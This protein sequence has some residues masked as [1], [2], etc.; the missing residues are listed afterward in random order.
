[1][2]TFGQA[3]PAKRWRLQEPKFYTKYG[4]I[5]DLHRAL[6][7]VGM[8]FIPALSINDP[9]TDLVDAAPPDTNSSV[10]WAYW[11]PT[12]E[13]FTVDGV[14][15]R[16]IFIVYA[17]WWEST[18]DP[19]E[20]MSIG[21]W[22]RGDGSI[23]D[24]DPL[25]NYINF[26]KAI[27]RESNNGLGLFNDSFSTYFTSQW[28]GGTLA[29]V[30]GHPGNSPFDQWAWKPY[31]SFAGNSSQQTTMLIRNFEVVLSKG[32]LLIKVG[33]GTTKVTEADLMNFYAAFGGGR[34]PT[35]ARPVLDDDNLD[36]INP[37]VI[38]DGHTEDPDW[39]PTGP[40]RIESWVVGIQH[41]FR[42]ET[43]NAF[44]LHLRSLENI[45]RPHRAFQNQETLPSPRDEAGTL[46]H[47]LNRCVYRTWDNHQDGNDYIGP[48]DVRV[49]PAPIQ[50]WE[51]WWDIPGFR[52][53]DKTAPKGDFVDAIG[54]EQYHAWLLNNIGV[55][56]AI[57]IEGI[58]DFSSFVSGSISLSETVDHWPM[59]VFGATSE[60]DIGGNDFQADSTTDLGHDGSIIRYDVTSGVPWEYVSGQDEIDRDTSSNTTRDL[61]FIIDTADISLSAQNWRLR[62]N[63]INRNDGGSD[64]VY[65]PLR[66]E[67]KALDGDGEVYLS[68]DN[69][70]K[71]S[72]GNFYQTN[73]SGDDR[74]TGEE[75]EVTLTDA[76]GH[77]VRRDDGKII[78][79][80]RSVHTS[81]RPNRYIKLSNVRLVWDE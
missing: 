76:D 59:D 32:G 20:E 63:L 68:L 60:T 9:E 43:D 1:M 3:I 80:V 34:I 58:T 55:L 65:N 21:V 12:S 29:A 75:I 70:G 5:H 37:I 49:S 40:E 71:D 74:Y 81:S 50:E 39:R 19:G 69:G 26:M 64:F 8:E 78:I 7:T 42:A 35:K 57:N 27:E 15:Y 62:F 28:L 13:T 24:G 30:G 46:A 66:V 52:W 36:R 73:N 10:F 16:P 6:V 22:L 18:S 17:P 56:A 44:R 23:R 51:D 79:R 72:D 54:G 61:E 48:L 38:I 33:Q 53:I 31:D 25:N 4:F 11:Y 77:K 14:D 47:I 67:F 45:S 2:A 41:D